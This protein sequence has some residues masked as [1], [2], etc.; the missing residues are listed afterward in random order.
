MT[1]G[2][3]HR[4]RPHL[5]L[6]GVQVAVGPLPHQHL[7]QR[8]AKGVHVDLQVPHARLV[9]RHP[10]LCRV[11]SKLSKQADPDQQSSAYGTGKPSLRQ[12]NLCKHSQTP[13]ALRHTTGAWVLCLLIL[14]ETQPRLWGSGPPTSSSSFSISGEA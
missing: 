6:E 9:L 10:L 12:E 2:C 13:G 1:A 5:D 8:H 3:R 11:N 4:L 14:H 7:P